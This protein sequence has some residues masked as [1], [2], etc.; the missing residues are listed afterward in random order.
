MSAKI[1]STVSLLLLVFPS[2]LFSRQVVLML[3]IL[4]FPCIIFCLIFF[5]KAHKKAGINLTVWICVAS[6]LIIVFIVRLGDYSFIHSTPI[7][8]LFIGLIIGMFFSIIVMVKWFWG[9]N[10]AFVRIV[11]FLTLLIFSA[12]FFWGMLLHF[13]YTFDFNEPKIYTLEIEEKDIDGG[14]HVDYYFIFSIDEK[15]LKVAVPYS[16]FFSH[17]VGDCYSVKLHQGAFGKEF[18]ISNETLE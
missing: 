14:K 11:I 4:L 10:T 2:I 3:Y 1:I 16:E 9:N 8:F 13:N 15:Q 6:Y 12:I 17:E 18:Y 5:F 7:S